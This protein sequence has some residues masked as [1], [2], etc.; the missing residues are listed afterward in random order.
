MS[1][2]TAARS[3]APA[4]LQ[5]VQARLGFTR[6]GEGLY[7]YAYEPP[8]GGPRTNITPDERLVSIADVRP[9]AD[10]F[11][12]DVEG[13]ALVR[14]QSA[15]RDFWDEAQTLALGHPE[16][17]EIVKSATGAS[18]VVV[19]DHTLRRRM[20]GAEDR[21]AGLPRQ[22]AT[23]VHVDQTLR[24]GPQ[25]VRDILGDQADDLLRRRAAIINVWRPIGAPARDWPLALGDAGSIDPADLLPS[26][27]RF[28]HR[29]GEIYGLAY[30]PSQRWCYVPD[31]RPDEALLI[32]CWDSADVARFAPHTAFEDPTT[33][34]GTPPRESIE[35]RTIAFFD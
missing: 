22:P 9:V 33:P 17:A 14:H 7:S 5:A 32:K 19:F 35:F 24:S 18:R 1:A 10:T 11:S 8:D 3:N 26:E 34:P 31:L 29:T 6:P 15:V 4:P 21:A 28:P 12:L 13:F 25:R 23:R 30:N 2:K 20:T 27:L 16:A